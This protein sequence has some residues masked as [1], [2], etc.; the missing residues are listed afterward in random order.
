M[1]WNKTITHIY[2]LQKT[3]DLTSEKNSSSTDKTVS[4]WHYYYYY[5]RGFTQ[6][7]FK[8]IYSGYLLNCRWYVI[9]HNVIKIKQSTASAPSSSS[10]SSSAQP[11]TNAITSEMKSQKFATEVC[12]HRDID[13]M[14]PLD[15]TH[16]VWWWRSKAWRTKHKM[17]RRSLSHVKRSQW[18]RLLRFIAL[19]T[20]T[21]Y[22]SCQALHSRTVPTDQLHEL[23]LNISVRYIHECR[24]LDDCS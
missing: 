8:V 9:K 16:Q 20:K 10:T 14:S 18:H 17:A 2:L 4:T 19:P 7:P 6:Y 12:L 3:I 5:Y 22:V 11:K 23:C 1:N 24:T 15:L 13:D 21:H